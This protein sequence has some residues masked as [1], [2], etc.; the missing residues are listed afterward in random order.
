MPRPRTPKTK[1]IATGRVL[2]DPKR[3]QDRD[4]PASQGPLG[5][6]PAWMTQHQKTAW[7]TFRDELP[8]LKPQPSFAH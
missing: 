5:I 1:A 4:E 7:T 6:A 8:W 3:F 2:H